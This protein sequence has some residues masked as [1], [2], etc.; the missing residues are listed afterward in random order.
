MTGGIGFSEVE[1]WLNDLP[2][3]VVRDVEQRP[4]RTAQFHFVVHTDQLSVNVRKRDREGPLVVAANVTFSPEMV[5]SIRDQ[6]HRFFGEVES[7]LT[8][9]PGIYAFT[10]GS[11]NS[12]PADR[13]TTVAIRHWVYPEGASKHAVLNDVIDVLSASSYVKDTAARLEKTPQIA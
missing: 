7:V 1:E 13:F 3:M 12:V 2:E 9:A 5:E 11:G 8:N 6:R 4:T 10:D